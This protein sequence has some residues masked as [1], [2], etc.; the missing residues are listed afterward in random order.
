MK[1]IVLSLFLVV[2]GPPVLFGQHKKSMT[3]T[4]FRLDEAVV[5]GKMPNNKKIELLNLDLPLKYVP[6]TVSILSSQLLERKGIFNL[7]DAVRFLP[8][9]I[10]KAP[11]YGAFQ[12][13]S[14]RGQGSAVVMIDGIRDER[15][16]G[17]NVPYGDL[18]SAE[19]IELIKGPVAVLS[20]HSAMGGVLNIVRKKAMPGFIGNARL[21]YGSWKERNASLG[22][23][24]KLAGPVNYRANVFYSTGDGWRQVNAD[25]FSGSLAL[26]SQ[27]GK[28]GQLDVNAGFNDDNYTTEIGG[29]PTM[30][31]DMFWTGTEDQ[32]ASKGERH[33]DADY[34]T[35]YQDFANNYMKR[36]NWDVS[37]Q[38]TQQLT[39]NLRLRERF[40][41]SHSDLD[42]HC[43]ESISYRESS[44]P[45]YKWYY[46]N[47]KGKTVYID[48][49]SVQRGNA[50]DL[51]PLN[52]NPDHK[53][54][55][56]VFELTGDLNTGFIKHHYILGWK[57]SNF[58][59]KQYQG[60]GK[61]DLWGPG[62]DVILPVRNPHIVQGW[63]D[64]KVSTVNLW[65]QANN[66][67]YLHDVMELSDKWKVMLAGKMD[68]YAQHTSKG[69]VD[70][71]QKYDPAKRT[72]DWVVKKQ[73]AFTYRAGLVYIPRPEI[74][75]YASMSSFFT[76]I[77]RYSYD[78][79]KMY[80][81]RNGKEFNPD[82]ESMFDPEK[83]WSLEVGA[84]YTLNEKLEINAS[85]YYIRKL[86][87]VKGLG[88]TVV[89]VDGVATTKSI[90][91]QVGTADSR[92]FDCELI[93]RPVSTLQITAG[94][95]WSDYRLREIR[96]SDQ[97]SQYKESNKG[98][99][100]TGVPRTTFYT[101]ADYTIPKGLLQNLSF[102][103]SA[104]FKDKVFRNIS[105]N[106]YFP[107]L[108]LMDGGIFYTIKS[109]VTVAVNVNNILGK[110]YF[111]SMTV[112]GKPR[113]FM[114]SVSYTF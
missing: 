13:F 44:D 43:I 55:N 10:E 91:G 78:P 70:G 59:M 96:K 51:N 86:N 99:R 19:S 63:W 75:L 67:I 28:G 101:Y 60:Y 73:S 2:L 6:V 3:D 25:R 47:S 93:A 114:A 79:K 106:T 95:G 36:K 33:P 20:G 81:D 97:F 27:I 50:A 48:L 82:E 64:T 66:G 12:Q 89:S 104:T 61:D 11:Q 26:S 32:Y 29:A 41:Y 74:S 15:T 90:L 72:Q 31:G 92:G 5:T 21:S 112:M 38:Y 58:I 14:I 83:G 80:L 9:I 56:N 39:G 42:Y 24:G 110:E 57:Y 111:T 4:I 108:W 102:H 77:T 69:T 103:L 105:D 100:A 22:F 88:D 16:V 52:F 8:G 62:L 30:P 85:L 54:W 76:P 71:E 46:K 35:V 109:H 37:V 40:T 23:G 1:R 113:N 17:N 34:H 87:M 49:D 65:R 84:R 94:I 68:F 107:S 7:E 45:I 98:V 18:S 53:T